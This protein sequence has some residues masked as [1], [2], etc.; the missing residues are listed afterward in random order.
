MNSFING[1]YGSSPR[2]RGARNRIRDGGHVHGLIPASAGST[3]P[4]M[5]FRL[6]LEGSS[7]RLRGAH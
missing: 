4:V 2:L 5:E 6:P 3:S 7:P 1:R